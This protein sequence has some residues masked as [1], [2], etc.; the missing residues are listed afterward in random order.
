MI[1]GVDI[2]E[3]LAELLEAY[4]R[5]YNQ[6]YNT[7]TQKEEMFSYSFREVLG[8]TEEENQQNLLDFFKSEYF[9]NIKP[10]KGALKSINLLA[11]KHRLCIITARPHIIQKETE[12]W[13]L[14]HF[15]DDFHS[16][17]LTNQWHGKGEKQLKSEVGKKQNIQIM[18]DD[19][20]Q[21]ALDCAAQGIYV[22]LADFSYPWNQTSEKL[23]ENI[24]RVRSWEEIVA[25]INSYGKKHGRG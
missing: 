10:V 11:Q 2:D 4:L 13:L 18:I 3:V 23:P 5:Y 16:I 22:L 24:K 8:G 25:E 17:N 19:S 12:Q 7:K 21:H 9:Q 6:K 15:P 20:L 1:I 14:K